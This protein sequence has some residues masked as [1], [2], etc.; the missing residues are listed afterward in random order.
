[1]TRTKAVGCWARREA[2]AD[3]TDWGAHVYGGN[4]S[5]EVMDDEMSS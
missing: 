5:D 2:N 1:M 4:D 3:S